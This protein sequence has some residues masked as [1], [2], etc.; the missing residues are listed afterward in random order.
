[1]LAQ[2]ELTLVAPS[3]EK[4]K[5][6][7]PRVAVLLRRPSGRKRDTSASAPRQPGGRPC[8]DAAEPMARDAEQIDQAVLIIS[9]EFVSSTTRTAIELLG[10][11]A[12]T[13]S[14]PGE[15][16][17]TRSLPSDRGSATAVVAERRPAAE[18][19][20]PTVARADRY[21]RARRA[22]RRDRRRR[23]RTPGAAAHRPRCER[24]RPAVRRRYRDVQQPHPAALSR[25]RTGGDQGARRSLGSRCGYGA[26][27]AGFAMERCAARHSRYAR[28]RRVRN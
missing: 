2:F 7:K 4:Q 15:S 10:D 6:D 9:G 22:S 16:D 26:R 1:M 11:S 14:R 3:A 25:A 12:H 27:S 24:H 17:D 20:W 19:T 21:R 23:P 5:R 28:W 8:G 13:C 18:I